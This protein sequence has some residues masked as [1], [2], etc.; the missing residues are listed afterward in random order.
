LNNELISIK[1]KQEQYQ[2]FIAHNQS[3]KE[4][5]DKKIKE[6]TTELDD[7]RMR[8]EKQKNDV[9]LFA[10]QLEYLQKDFDE[11]SVNYNEQS[12]QYNQEN[13][14]FHQQKNRTSN[15]EKD[16]EYREIQL[17][18]IETRIKQHEEELERTQ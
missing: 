12:S 6:L 18:N 7:Q 5:I 10:G 3:R 16:L 13:I 8:L 1:T 17:E 2:S 11:V 4:S 15:L 9:S 14:T